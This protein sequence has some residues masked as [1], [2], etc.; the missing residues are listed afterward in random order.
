L[1]QNDGT[2][3]GWKQFSV[4]VPAP[5]LTVSNVASATGG[6]V[7]NLANLIT[8]SDPS[9]VGYQKLELWD[10]AG[11]VT[12]GQF[13]INGTAQTG[14]HE[15]DVTPANVANTVFDTGTFG[16]T[17]TLWAQ[18][19]QNDGTLSGWKQFSVT[20]PAPTLTVSN[21]A[22]ATG[23]Q[24]I[25]LANLIT[26]SDPSSVGYQKLEL[27]DSAGTVTGGQFK[28]NGTAQTG[29]H[30]IDVTPANVANTVFDAGTFGV[31]D[32]LWAQLQ[33]NDGTLSGWKQ[34]SVTVPAP[35]LTVS[36]VAGAT[37]G[38]VI[39]LANLITISDP[40]SVGYQKLELWDS[41]GT[42]T[43]GQFKIN[44][45]AQT[46]GHE[47]DVTP[48]NVANT[49]FDTGTFGGT[50]TL[51]AQLMQ[52][53]GTLSG[54][55]QFSVTV[56]AP[57][58]TVSNVASATGGQVINLANLITISDP[59]SVGYQKLELW[60]SAGT[61]TGGQ[62]KI[63][64][65]AQTGGHEIDVIPVN[66]ANT[67]FDAGTF[68][69]TDTLWAQLQQNDGTL[70]GWK[71]FSVTVPA[72]TLTVSNVAGATGGQVIN[73]ANLITIS[74]PSSVGYQKLELWDSAGTV[75]GGQFK[76]NGTAQTGGH[77]ID[78]TPANVANTVFD[79]G[80]FGGTDTL[81]AQ[82]MQND[83]TLSG[84][85][86]FSVTVPAPTL[87]VSNVASATGG[88]VINLA[89]LITISD[90]SSV[91][92]QKLE[93]W[94]SAGTVTGGQ[95][96]INGTAQTGGH[97]IDVIPV[98][99]ANT[100]FDAGTFGVTDT[101]WAQ[102]QQNDGTLSGWKQ[103]SVTVPA[104]TLTVS[105]VAGATGGQVINL[106]NLITIS[107]PSSVGYQKLELWDSAGTVT[108]GQF[109]I[110]GTAQTGGHEIDVI[111]VNFANTVFDAGTFG[112][113]DTL[114]AQLQQNDGTL[115]GWKQ[116][117]V[118]VPA[119]TLTVSNVAGAT[120]GQVIN[121][122]NLITISDPS[123]VG[124][125]KL[126]LWDSVG[127]V[128]GGQFKINGTAQTGGHEIDVTPANVANTVFDTGTFGG[129]DTL[130]AQL[131]Q[132]DGTLSGWKQ[133]SVVVPAPKV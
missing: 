132:N 47:I 88:Q 133:F 129:T 76:I 104:P 48:A 15:I 36:N 127:T 43:G 105:N 61:V 60:D 21:V 18:L 51:W 25:N 90:P 37:G 30:E 55:K 9:S 115:S 73:L 63:N 31:T 72:P 111:P 11:T 82:L 56:P 59:S 74:D 80:T 39:N 14:G 67:V 42:V 45:T 75:T 8:I 126:E 116:F 62:F 86:Q 69:V 93:L 29:G 23:G 125:Q 1:M 106:A 34:F 13:K 113:T 27:W 107:D 124:Y 22:S 66:F 71:Q 119:P 16:G 50:D 5:T 110:N 109:K 33:Q 3:S 102:L 121:L 68:G 65:T 70:S 96:K 103:F 44:G 20:V 87:T 57:T 10:S 6:Q 83:G 120:G 128:T 98:N 99:F 54:W 52:N 32:T 40:S 41:A 2:L 64:G 122:A 53:D 35:T 84:W 85:K 78:V 17:D 79:T 4:T 118:T 49:V 58:L 112:G 89:N 123:S 7:I 24:V 114:W 130:W 12:G 77:E 95:F 97:E 26:I 91:G 28:I 92:Y 117:S 19:M 101:L 94:D 81:W 38:Q 100:V 108:G 131:M 46:G